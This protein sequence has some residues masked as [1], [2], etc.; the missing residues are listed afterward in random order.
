[1]RREA[2]P[3]GR[4]PVCLREGSVRSIVVRSDRVPRLTARIQDQTLDFLVVFALRV[5]IF[6]GAGSG[7]PS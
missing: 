7:R 3:L 2:R 6:A 1:M 4:R 5:P